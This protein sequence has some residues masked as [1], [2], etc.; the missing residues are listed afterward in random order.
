MKTFT[1]GE[2]M[3]G[4]QGMACECYGCGNRTWTIVLTDEEHASL[5]EYNL[6][7]GIH[8]RSHFIFNNKLGVA[9]CKECYHDQTI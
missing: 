8:D 3:G 9:T 5:P 7:S 4:S 6:E 1:V 2:L